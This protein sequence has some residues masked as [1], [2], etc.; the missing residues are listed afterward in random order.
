MLLTLHSSSMSPSSTTS[1]ADADGEGIDSRRASPEEAPLGGG[2]ASIIEAVRADHVEIR[3]TVKRLNDLCTQLWCSEVPLDPSPAALIEEFG[4]LLIP[5][6]ATEEIGEFFGSLVTEEPRLLH[7]VERLEAEH[8]DMLEAL[9]HLL[10]FAKD[11]PVA[12]DLATRL[13][14]FLNWFEAHEHTENALM[15]EF[16]LLDEGGQD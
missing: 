3:E 8:R 4:A 2:L 13:A 15:Q 6:F 14:N 5:H 1:V 7:R 10:V 16:L 9:D 12:P 11:E